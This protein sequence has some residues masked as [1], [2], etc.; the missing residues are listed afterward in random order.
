MSLLHFVKHKTRGV[1]GGIYGN[2]SQQVS[3]QSRWNCR[4]APT[5]GTLA[6]TCW[7]VDDVRSHRCWAGR[8]GNDQY[9]TSCLRDK[10][11]IALTAL[12]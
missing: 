2:R 5:A 9:H 8:A 1:V 3:L 4:V 10:R 7:P 6:S 12:K 11:L